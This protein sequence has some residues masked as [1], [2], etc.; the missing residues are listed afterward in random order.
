MN[1]TVNDVTYVVRSE[2]ELLRLILRLTN[3]RQMKQS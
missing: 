3:R 1:I 2:A